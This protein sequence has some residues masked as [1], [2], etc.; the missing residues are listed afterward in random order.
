[1]IFFP[2]SMLVI[3][4][5]WPFSAI[6]CPC[7]SI[8][9]DVK[10]GGDPMFTSTHSK[11]VFHRPPLGYTWTEPLCKQ[12]ICLIVG[13]CQFGNGNTPTPWLM[14]WHVVLFSSVWFDNGTTVNK[15]AELN[16]PCASLLFILTSTYF[17]TQ[18]NLN[19]CKYLLSTLYGR[20]LE[21][22]LHICMHS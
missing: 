10:K 14:Q 1:M 6:N 2:R 15:F 16:F 4:R 7:C 12:L 17:I 21:N 5:E 20:L 8:A 11:I 18:R 3:V 9:I 19:S 22:T 13:I